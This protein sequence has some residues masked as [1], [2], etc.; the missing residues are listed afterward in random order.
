[1]TGTALLR[2]DLIPG[3][4]LKLQVS[5]DAA[6]PAG[7]VGAS[8][9]VEGE[10]G[11][12]GEPFSG[13]LDGEASAAVGA[14]GALAVARGWPRLVFESQTTSD[15]NA[16]IQLTNLGTTALYFTWARVDRGG[17]APIE[18]N[19]QTFESQTPRELSRFGCANLTGSVLPGRKVDFT[20]SFASP[21]P[22]RTVLRA[23]SNRT[24]C[25]T[26]RVAC[27]YVSHRACS[28]NPG[29]S[30]LCRQRTR[31]VSSASLCAVLR[32]PWMKV[33]QCVFC[34]ALA[35][36]RVPTG[37]THPLVSALRGAHAEKAGRAPRAASAG[38]CR[39]GGGGT[40][41]CEDAPAATHR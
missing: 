8:V 34:F 17:P 33:C 35:R 12:D 5:R 11:P 19:G 22:V 29:S 15:A 7:A 32:P 30:A 20:F 31:A 23:H 3:P 38:A 39:G 2:K 41:S 40:E 14:G 4:W 27:V 26:V 36:T 24:L 10:L 9:G 21:N 13:T 18:T 25:M 16:V 28:V 6:T 1:M 37:F